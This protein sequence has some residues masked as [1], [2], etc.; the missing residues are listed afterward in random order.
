[1]DSTTP[2]SVRH[3]HAYHKWRILFNWETI[4]DTLSGGTTAADQI[5]RNIRPRF[6]GKDLLDMADAARQSV[7]VGDPLRV[8]MDAE[9]GSHL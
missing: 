1:M 5:L 3:Y 9:M 8:I 2:A 4:I 6:G 7:P